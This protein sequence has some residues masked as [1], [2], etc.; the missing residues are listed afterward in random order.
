MHGWT[1][2]SWPCRNGNI[3]DY[4]LVL[5]GC[6]RG[7]A[8]NYS[9]GAGQGSKSACLYQ[10]KYM[11]KESVAIA[12]VQSVLVDAYNHNK[13]YASTA[14]DAGTQ[15]RWAK[16]FCQ[17]AINHSTIE[18]EGVQAASLITSLRSSGSSDSIN[19]FSGWDVERVA[20][21]VA[22]G[23]ID[24][25]NFGSEVLGGG[26]AHE[27]DDSDNEIAELQRGITADLSDGTTATPA[28]DLLNTSGYVPDLGFDGYAQV[29][30]NSVNENVPV[31]QAHHYIYRDLL[32][33]RFSAYEFV[34][35]YTVRSMTTADRKWHDAVTAAQPQESVAIRGVRTC[36]RFLLMAPHPLHDSHILV[37]RTKLGV[38]AFAGAP[39]P[40]DAPSLH[41][42]STITRK[43]KR[44]A[45]FF[46]SNF[47][48][49]SI[50]QP[51]DLS[52]SAWT[53]HLNTTR[54]EA[55]RGIEREPD[56][57]D[58]MSQDDKD[59][60]SSAKR[61]RLIA[62]GRLY[63]ID[64]VTKCFQAKRTAVVV[65]AKM[66]ARARTI[67]SA[68]GNNKPPAEAAPAE[69]HRAAKAIRNLQAKA[70]RIRGNDDMPSRLNKVASATKWAND[71]R[72]ALSHNRFQARY[73]S[74]TPQRLQ[75]IWKKAAFP[76]KRSLKGGIR[77]PVNF[78]SLLK[79]PIVLTDSNEWNTGNLPVPN[80]GDSNFSPDANTDDMDLFAEISE[81][82]YERAATEH[83]ASGLPNADAPLN[84]EQR[85][86]GREIIKVAMLNK[87]L[88]AQG[89]SPSAITSAIK[90]L[91]ISQISLMHGRDHIVP[92]HLPNLTI[93]HCAL[94]PA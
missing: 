85:H 30:R 6:T 68:S 19:Y 17:R 3:A 67:W 28:I 84:P 5:S 53:N 61:S 41:S 31:S 32:L 77:D 69:M 23:V 86:C 82:A 15:D 60:I 8:V 87:E 26:P 91:Q 16:Y 38:P 43:R 2:D 37:P 89:L 56:I 80:I 34:R 10:I 42:N 70:D 12:A 78:V 36:H 48:P 49:W 22:R 90:G 79:K 29:F 51:P 55:C 62:H 27:S 92:N 35:L 9:L 88:K 94:T 46:M 44:F 7:N 11:S 40:S 64:N 13:K 33:W 72:N 54:R 65:L 73:P 57:T 59:A 81:I 50:A 24:D 76:T 75:S 74:D 20:R 39:P 25:V 71:L 4:S 58:V 93:S 18:L 83:K 45:S 63:D 1:K 66:R 47:V 21:I 52:Y 14:E